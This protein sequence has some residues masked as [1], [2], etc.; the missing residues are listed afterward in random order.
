MTV[1]VTTVGGPWLTGQLAALARQTRPPA[2]LVVVN[3]GPAGAVDAVVDAWREA[4]PQMELVEDRSAAICGHAR[5]VGAARARQPGIL[6][7]DDDDVVDPGYVAAMGDALDRGELA[8]A[9]IDLE[10]LNTDRLA[11]RWGDMQAA[12][13]MTYHDFLPWVIGGAMGIRQKTF[14]EVDG[15]DTSLLV[16]EDTDLSWRAQLDADARIVFAPDARISY[17][18]RTAAR[19]AFRQARSW[20]SWEVE[21]YRRY[22]S[23]GLVAGGSRLRALLRWARPLLLLI[24]ARQ[25]EDV[26]VAAR[27]LGA[28]V[29]RLEGSVRHRHL[30][31]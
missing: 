29:G 12:G 25:S 24:R 5:N 13:P 6:F 8:A 21:L 18:L 7:L 27:Q 2:Q 17:R 26:V 16:G 19:P 30:H 23:R 28:C 31:L 3:N 14:H 11:A 15:F 20:A 4:L 22:R 9:S 1:V 10:Q